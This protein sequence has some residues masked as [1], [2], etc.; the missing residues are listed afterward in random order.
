M[1]LL[2]YLLTYSS[3]RFSTVCVAV[4]HRW[5]SCSHAHLHRICDV[6]IYDVGDESSQVHV[7]IHREPQMCHLVYDCNYDVSLSSF[8]KQFYTS[9]NGNEYSLYS[10]LFQRLDDVTA[11]PRNSTSHSYFS[12]LNMLNFVYKILMKETCG[13]ANDFLPED[14]YMNFPTILGKDKRCSSVEQRPLFS[15]VS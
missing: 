7:V 8:L 2:T 3:N 14:R 13:N 5:S 12:E 6:T 11:A 15:L 4:Q 10:L 1:F 9:W